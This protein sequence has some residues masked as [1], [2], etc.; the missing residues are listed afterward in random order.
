[1]NILGNYHWSCK[2]TSGGRKGK[3]FA[4]ESGAQN[5]VDNDGVSRGRCGHP[6]GGAA[7]N[8]NVEIEKITRRVNDLKLVV[9]RF[10]NLN[11]PIFCGSEE[12]E[13]A[14]SWL[15]AMNNLFV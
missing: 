6:L 15:R 5:M 9:E 7:Q 3:G 1:M 13:K 11:P 10:H 12:N 8:V 4:Q 2:M 14:E